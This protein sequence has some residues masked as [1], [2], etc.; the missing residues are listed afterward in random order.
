MRFLFFLFLAASA[1]AQSVGDFSINYKANSTGPQSLKSWSKANSTLWGVDSSGNPQSVT[2]GSGL[3][4]ASGVLTASGGGVGTG[5]VTSVGLTMPNI[6]SVTGSPVTASGTL[7]ASLATQTANT[8]FA[9]PTTGSAAAPTFRAL[10]AADIPDLSGTYQPL[11]AKLATLATGF[12]A[13]YS[14]PAFLK[15]NGTSYEL[16]SGAL[17]EIYGG[18]G[19]STYTVGDTLYASGGGSLAKLV[20]NTSTTKKY[21]SQTGTG[22]ASA[23]P[24]WEALGTLATQNGTFSGT[25]SGTN[26]GDQTITLLG[27]VTGSGSGTF[28]ATLPTVNSNVGS[29][30]SATAAPAVT[31]NAKGL[32]TGVTTSTITPAVGSITGLG[33]G[34]A[35]WLA[36][37]TETNLKA[38]QSGLSWLDTAQTFTAAQTVTAPANN[39]GITVNGSL[40]GGGVTRSLLTVS[41]NWTAATGGSSSPT[42]L[43]LVITD[44]GASVNYYGTRALRIMR[45]G[46]EVFYIDHGG[47]MYIAGGVSINGNYG[48]IDMPV[49][50]M[51]RW[52]NQTCLSRVAN[53]IMMQRSESGT[54]AQSLQ[55]ANTVT[56]TTS[57]E[58]GVLDW[59]TTTNTLR[60]GTDVG[61]G[62]GTARDVQ[63]I[64]GGVVKSTLG[65]NTTDHDQ[66]VKLKSYIVSGLPSAS[67][68]GAGS[69][70][71][72]TDATA[73]TA[74][75]TVAGGGSNKVLVISDGTN[76]VIH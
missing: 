58:A 27:D 41:D 16:K 14:Q 24:V 67:T 26:T 30:G 6:F 8:V 46:G 10:D 62:G 19:Q 21:L 9:G 61:S 4:L 11:N 22:S 36:T 49:A 29:F 31:V 55:V 56:S 44:S 20:G 40:T 17:E 74:Y 3:S 60:I 50:W 54:I 25:S 42:L 15:W 63:L 5:T 48:I 65:A 52:S 68:C 45:N 13:I 18:T 33:T 64:R 51:L 39:A 66:P 35:T 75:S 47:S 32:I 2:I 7:A 34:I 76:W 70:A 69:M 53:G 38:A 71:F 57:W 12:G 1:F 59:K 72:V 23:A 28:T 37:P 73:T 43:D